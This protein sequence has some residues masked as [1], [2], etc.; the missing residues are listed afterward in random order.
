MTHNPLIVVLKHLV[1]QVLMKESEGI[2]VIEIGYRLFPRTSSRLEMKLPF[3]EWNA[4]DPPNEPIL[5]STLV[6][7][8]HFLLA[9]DR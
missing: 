5:D 8:L 1:L 6:I 3:I 2:L 4:R 9:I 7:I